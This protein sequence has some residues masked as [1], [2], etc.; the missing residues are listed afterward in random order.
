[1][2]T[3]RELGPRGDFL[4]PHRSPCLPDR[5][6][7]NLP[8]GQENASVRQRADLAHKIRA[9]PVE[10]RGL[11]LVPWRRAASGGGDEDTVEREPVVGAK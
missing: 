7:P 10:L 8:E 1:M 5:V 2:R 11:R 4:A 9:A 6:E 3:V